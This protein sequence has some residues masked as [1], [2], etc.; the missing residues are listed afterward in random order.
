[1]QFQFQQPQENGDIGG[2]DGPPVGGSCG[3]VQTVVIKDLGWGTYNS[4]E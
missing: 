4:S 1:M 2:Q 3:G